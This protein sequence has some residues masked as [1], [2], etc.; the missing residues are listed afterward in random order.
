MCAKTINY[1]LIINVCRT[2]IKLCY[3]HRPL[4]FLYYEKIFFTWSLIRDPAHRPPIPSSSTCHG[5]LFP[6]ELIP[7]TILNPVVSGAI[8][9]DPHSTG[10][11]GK[12]VLTAM[13]LAV[14]VVVFSIVLVLELIGL[15]EVA[16]V[17]LTVPELVKVIVNVNDI[18]LAQKEHDLVFCIVIRPGFFVVNTLPSGPWQKS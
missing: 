4:L 6:L 16:V 5:Q 14:I 10:N 15:V 17:C 11:I 7:P 1:F 9:G 8:A 2:Y 18:G 13:V 12:V 3:R